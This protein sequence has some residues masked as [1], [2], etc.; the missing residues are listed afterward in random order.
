MTAMGSSVGEEQDLQ[1]EM[2]KK[3]ISPYCV[4]KLRQKRQ[5]GFKWARGEFSLWH[6]SPSTSS[7]KLC[8]LLS[9][10][11]NTP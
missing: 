5:G 9:Q 7:G 3:Q 10:L 2:E 1:S 4:G 11:E 6:S 8:F